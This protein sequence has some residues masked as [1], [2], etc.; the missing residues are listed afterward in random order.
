MSKRLI[1]WLS[2][3]NLTLVNAKENY[4]EK[5]ILNIIR[6][7]NHLYRNINHEKNYE[8]K[9]IGCASLILIGLIFEEYK[10]FFNLGLEIIKK[11]INTNFDK[12]G[13]PYTRNI[14]E[15]ME[16]LKYF[17]IIREWIK[18]SQTQIPEFL[19]NIIYNS[20]ISFNFINEQLDKLPLFN[21]SSEIENKDFKTY[22]NLSGYTFKKKIIQLLEVDIL[23]LKIRKLYLLWILVALL[24]KNIHQNINVVVFH[25]KF[26]Q[27]KINLLQIQAFI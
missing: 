25:L 3:T 2:N 17:I 20:G 4:K 24:M 27:I 23:F 10:K 13:F 5:F 19:D 15:L 21:G 8:N 26:F 18:E 14:Q 22:L 6:Q 12:D 16:C 7:T 1:S 11:T 9:I